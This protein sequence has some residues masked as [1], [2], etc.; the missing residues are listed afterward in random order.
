MKNEIVFYDEIGFY[1]MLMSYENTAPMQQFANEVL[2]PVIQ[3]EEK[4]YT[5]K[6]D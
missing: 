6:A 1:R 3:Y 5:H 2:S 4:A